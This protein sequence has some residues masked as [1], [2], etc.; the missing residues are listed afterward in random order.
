MLEDLHVLL[1]PDSLK[2]ACLSSV[3]TGRAVTRAMSFD[4]ERVKVKAAEPTA[5]S[6]FVGIVADMA[7]DD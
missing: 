6:V 7:A 5:K 3:P 4:R 2:A 1:F